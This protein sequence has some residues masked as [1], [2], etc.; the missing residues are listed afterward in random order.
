MYG[1]GT[2]QLTLIVARK[3]LRDAALQLDSACGTLEVADGAGISY[4]TEAIMD[5]QGKSYWRSK[6][7]SP[8]KP[9]CHVLSSSVSF[10]FA[11]RLELPRNVQT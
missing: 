7:E 10:L 6:Q 8:E 2:C 4:S 1:K 5:L 3:V 9:I 11:L